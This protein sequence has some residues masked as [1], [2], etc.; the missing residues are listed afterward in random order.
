MRPIIE[1]ATPRL[2]MVVWREEH[3]EPF[4]AMNADAEVMRYFASTQT[5]DQSRASVDAW[6]AQFAEQGWSNWAVE[7]TSTGQFIGFIGL[8]VPRRQFSFSPC[9]EIGWRL[10][11][12]FWGH[13]YATEGARSCLQV[14]FERLALDDIVSFTSLLNRPS[15]AVMERIGM[16][17]TLCDFEHPALP[18]GHAL[19]PH[20]LYRITR[21][22]WQSQG[23]A[24]SADGVPA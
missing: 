8:S 2:R 11:R 24:G 16:H 23:G 18:E 1:H 3:L 10:A 14:G 5:A 21:S 7:L 22:E 20:C 9:V 13:G 15:R 12:E 6:R 19:R 4:A 17:N